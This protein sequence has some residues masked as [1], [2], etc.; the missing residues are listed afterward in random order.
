M[1]VAAVVGFR[2]FPFPLWGRPPPGSGGC[3]P[4]GGGGETTNAVTGSEILAMVYGGRGVLAHG[5][6]PPGLAGSDTTRRGYGYDPAAARTLL[7]EAGD[8]GGIGVRLWRTG[9][10]VELSR[11]AQAIQAQLAGVG[12]AGEAV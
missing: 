5:A 1:G 9:T 12:G 10:N 4:P 2:L 3:L 7:T 11:V 8:S 6:I